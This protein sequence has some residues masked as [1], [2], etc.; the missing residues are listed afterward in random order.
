MSIPQ[1]EAPKSIRASRGWILKAICLPSLY[2]QADGELIKDAHP[3][4]PRFS[5]GWGPS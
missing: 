5:G 4:Q 2:L 1:P 3:Q